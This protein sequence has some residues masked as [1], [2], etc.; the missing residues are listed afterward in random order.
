MYG[1][2]FLTL[3]GEILSAKTMESKTLKF[4]K[5]GVGSGDLAN[6]NDIKL[7]NDLVN[8]VLFF[9]I[10]KISRENDNQIYI[11]GIFRNIDANESFYLKELG[12]YAIDPDTQE[13]VLFA[14]INYGDKAEYI[15]NSETER[16]ERYYNMIIS[17]DNAD[18]VS[19]V[20]ND[21]ISYVTEQEF[22]NELVYTYDLT[23]ILDNWVLNNDTHYYEYNITNENITS[24]TK[25]DLYPNLLNQRKIRDGEV[26]SYDGGFKISTTEMPEED[27]DLTVY[28]QLSHSMGG[29][30]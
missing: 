7:L 9:D 25:V 15:N 2:T 16:V 23:L 4:S 5:F 27:I 1:T 6:T 12:L 8:P 22:N 10:A 26:N 11:K 28:Y 19:L 30:V 24:N 20:V 18:N 29:N 17:V 13:E 21:T 3:K 14:Y